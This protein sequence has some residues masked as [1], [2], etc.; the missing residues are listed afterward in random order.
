VID[1]AILSTII[2]NVTLLWNVQKLTVTG[3]CEGKLLESMHRNDA[4]VEL[5]SGKF[6][7]ACDRDLEGKLPTPDEISRGLS[8]QRYYDFGN[9]IF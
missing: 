9:L 5:C 3:V 7:V 1:H 2:S 4:V 6:K 8:Y